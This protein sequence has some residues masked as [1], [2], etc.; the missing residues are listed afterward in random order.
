MTGD[1]HH[2]ETLEHR[3]YWQRAPQPTPRN[4]GLEELT[5]DQ[6]VKKPLI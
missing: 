4:G 1:L 6:L 5:V 3:E 2:A